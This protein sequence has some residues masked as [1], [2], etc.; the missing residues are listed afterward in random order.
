MN[1]RRTAGR[2]LS[3]LKK[4]TGWREDHWARVVYIDEWKNFFS[5]LPLKTLSALE[6]S[7][8]N[9]SHWREIGFRSY[10]GA[11]YP[12]F[13]ITKQTLP[14][15]FD[16][17]IAEHVFEHLSHPYEAA[18]NVHAMLRPEGMFLIA[19]PFLC[20]IHA[21]PGD[22]TRWSV[23]GLEGFLRETGFDP[24]VH[25]W[26]NRRCVVA[27]FTTW[28]QYGWRRDLRNEPDFPCVVW[29][30]AR[31]IKTDPLSTADPRE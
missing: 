9:V 14:R 30:Y 29:A 2:Y 11:S 5:A 8:G 31:S 7:P 10:E 12:D 28:P 18:R 6:I 1:W 21:H 26:G 17:V 24:Q 13:D 19:T 20:R 23:Q 16:V 3:K 27:N 4:A 25:A 15:T 22:Y